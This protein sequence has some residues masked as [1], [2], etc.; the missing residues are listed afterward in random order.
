METKLLQRTDSNKPLSVT[1][2]DNNYLI[3]EKALFAISELLSTFTEEKEQSYP[4]R[5]EVNYTNLTPDLEKFLATWGLSKFFGVKDIGEA[6]KQLVLNRTQM[7]DELGILDYLKYETSD[8]GVVTITGLNGNAILNDTKLNKYFKVNDDGNI[9][10]NNPSNMLKEIGAASEKDVKDIQQTIKVRNDLP[11]SFESY[12]WSNISDKKLLITF[13][14]VD[15][16]ITSDVKKYL[17]EDFDDVEEIYI[18]AHAKLDLFI[19]YDF[20][21]PVTTDMIVFFTAKKEN[22]GDDYCEI[23]KEDTI[24]GN[25]TTSAFGKLEFTPTVHEDEGVSIQLVAD[26]DEEFDDDESLDDYVTIN[27]AEVTSEIV[28]VKYFEEEDDG[29]ES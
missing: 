5:E 9:V 8:E 20:N 12:Y 4:E 25:H 10:I 6:G 1:E 19:G 23:T 21:I 14:H 11:K 24:I 17:G 15:E 16:Y 2:F 22:D 26:F 7:L 18:K 28:A 27:R 29:E 13:L 3:I